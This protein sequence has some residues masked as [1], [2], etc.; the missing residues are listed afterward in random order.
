M[1]GEVLFWGINHDKILKIHNKIYEFSSIM[2]ANLFKKLYITGIRI[3]K[4]G[5]RP[6]RYDDGCAYVF[7]VIIYDH[8]CFTALCQKYTDT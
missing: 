8:Q 6:P 2:D 3:S 4:V 7:G 5:N 1:T